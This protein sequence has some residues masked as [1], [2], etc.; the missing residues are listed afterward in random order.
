MLGTSIPVLIIIIRI[1]LIIGQ[2]CRARPRA[3]TSAMIPQEK[4]LMG[5][6]GY[7]VPSGGRLGR[8]SSAVIII[9]FIIIIIYA[10]NLWSCCYV[11]RVVTQPSTAKK[12]LVGSKFI[13]M[14]KA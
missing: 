11:W 6:Y 12:Q 1:L 4:Q 5:F 14:Y 2:L 13:F 9:N 10:Y 3:I 7:G 8:W